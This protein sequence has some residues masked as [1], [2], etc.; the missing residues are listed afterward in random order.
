MRIFQSLLLA[1]TGTAA[2]FG[3]Q[4]PK[5][6]LVLEG[7]GAL[8]FAH[9]GAIQ[10]IEE[11]HIPVDYVAGT[12][13]GGLV[14]GL[15]AAG[16]GPA[17]IR[18]IVA[19]INWD[20]VLAGQTPFRDL[21][22]RRKED[23]VAYP[24]RIELGLRHGLSLPGGL[25]SGYQ[26]GLLFDRT[27]ISYHDLKSF[28]D[29]PIPFRC[30]ATEMVAGKKKVFDSGSLP[31]A[32]RATMSIPGVFAPVEM[33]GNLYTDGGAVDNLPVDEAKKM[34]ADIIIAVYLD[35]GPGNPRSYKS[36][37][38]AAARSISIMVSVNEMHSI[39]A[40]DVL[41][42]AD[43]KDFTAGDFKESDKIAPKGF[44]AAEKK[45]SILSKF[46][47]SDDEWNRYVARRTSRRR[48][49]VPV[50]QFLEVKGSTP[51]NEQAVQHALKGF[52][53]KPIDP[54]AL[55]AQMTKIVGLGT[56]SSL[57]YSLAKKDDQT[58]LQIQATEKSYGPP[59]LN[60][61]ATIDG[62][63]VNDVRFGMA[64]RFTFLNVGGYRSEWR[65]DVS[66]GSTYLAQTEYYHP[67][68]ENSR[69]FV[70]PRLYATKALFDIY[71][72]TDRVAQYRQTRNGF[73][74][75]LGYEFNRY[76]ELRVGE[77]LTWFG[78]NRQIGTP[79]VEDS[80]NRAAVSSL[81]FQYL[82]QD[83]A[84]VP[85]N[86]LINMTQIQWF[87]SRPDG[88]GYPSAE[89]RTSYFHQVSKPGS[90]F[91]TADGGTT[92]GTSGLQLQSFALGGPLRLGAYGTNELLGNQYLLFQGGYLHQLLR[93]NPLIG[94]AVYGTVFYE[95][96]KIY[97]NPLSNEP[98]VAM[99]GSVAV[100]MK[101]AIGPVY[102]GGSL[103]NNERR[104]W[105][106]GLGRV[107]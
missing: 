74:G 76:A 31:Q 82:G 20:E 94:D 89:I 13:M 34:G 69:W 50:P 92:F 18:N 2:L 65:S 26:V 29:L 71:N 8:G 32:L 96:G 21:A 19:Q 55:E 99:D 27:L 40:A 100:I 86:G 12:S 105:W 107:F 58:G 48:T 9:I 44:E 42:S 10:W 38:G 15:Y 73:G 45:K 62:S 60:V 101:T 28:D 84:V 39:E 103:G 104:K 59:F 3:Q 35:T 11:H 30:V 87:S 77:D 63:D 70:A 83:D 24:N 43:L 81:R 106:F 88:G 36:V 1:A 41:I 37:L 47:V 14:A 64:A 4:H 51:K 22:Y 52:A 17:D 57:D 49:E 23:R 5:I 61:A 7:G 98:T 53:G 78:T 102:V 67:L 68:Q 46:A 72:D 25:N 75:D 66:F 54:P 91:V 80:T 93:L 97:S 6:G 95:V 85:R 56:F 33:N 90:I 79:V 16:Y